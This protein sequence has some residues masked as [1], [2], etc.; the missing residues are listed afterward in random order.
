MPDRSRSA[1]GYG[2]G[3][4]GGFLSFVS[5]FPFA[6]FIFWIL[7]HILLIIRLYPYDPIRETLIR[8]A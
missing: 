3:L 1:I 6:L 7:P 2:I 5:L 4:C 8:D